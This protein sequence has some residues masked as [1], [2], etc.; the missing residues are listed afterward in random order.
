MLPQPVERPCA[1][2]RSH[3]RHV[4]IGRIGVGQHGLSEP[5]YKPSHPG[6]G[7]MAASALL[8]GLRIA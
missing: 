3:A 5:L 6:F 8:S 2:D 7:A 4:G 1:R